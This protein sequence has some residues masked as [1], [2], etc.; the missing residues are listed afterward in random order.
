MNPYTPTRDSRGQSPQVKE[1][2]IKQLKKGRSPKR[3]AQDI[4]KL[5]NEKVAMNTIYRWRNRYK[6]VT[7]EEILPWYKLNLTH[8]QKNKNR[9][10]KK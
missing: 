3:I 4:E 5:F 2:A 10:Y 8:E 1:W 9:S 7:G 6:E